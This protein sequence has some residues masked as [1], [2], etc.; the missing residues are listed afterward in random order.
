[1]PILENGEILP[2]TDTQKRSG[3]C[4]GRLRGWLFLAKVTQLRFTCQAS[5]T[6]LLRLL[7]AEGIC[8]FRVHF[9]G[10]CPLMAR[11][12]YATFDIPEMSEACYR[13][14][15][16]K[17]QQVNL[18]MRTRPRISTEKRVSRYSG[19]KEASTMGPEFFYEL[20]ERVYREFIRKE[21]IDR[22]KTLLKSKHLPWKL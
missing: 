9:T 7:Y 13:E 22:R 1:M 16:S 18:T 2:R 20:G 3:D 14:Q 15:L 4:S 6:P 19:Q 12:K 17:K 11:M 8:G 5:T 21:E 10:Q